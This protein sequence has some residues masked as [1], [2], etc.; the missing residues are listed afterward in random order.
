MT[1]AF[2]KHQ[3]QRLRARFGEKNFDHEFIQ[4]VWREVY[5]MDEQAFIKTVDV[6]IG[7]RT[8]NRPPLLTDFRDARLAWQKRKFDEDLRG[9][10]RFLQKRAPEEMRNHLRLVLSKD[11]GGVESVTDALEIAKLKRQTA[12]A[13]GQDPDGAA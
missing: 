2:F 5:D 7:T 11:F 9:A 3:V 10:T 4:L 13:N 6:M 1:D 12:R 8:P